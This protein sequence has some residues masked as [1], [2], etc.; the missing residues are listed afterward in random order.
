[1]PEDPGQATPASP[2]GQGASEPQTIDVGGQQMTPDALSKSYGELRQKLTD[3]GTELNTARTSLEG[4]AWADELQSRYN[5]D[6]TFRQSFDALFEEQTGTQNHALRPEN[7]ELHQT[8][9]EVAEMRNERAFD[10]IRQDG[11]ELS[12]D[13]ELAVLKEINAGPIKDAHAVYKNLFFDRALAKAR[14]QGVTDTAEQLSKNKDAY[15]KKPTAQGSPKPA[16]DVKSMSEEKRA[17]Y[18]LER[19]KEM[20]LYHQ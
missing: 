12:K 19:I 10:R 17:D 6:P 11:F 20:D 7:Q 8:R 5:T 9:M 13:D 16:P 18:L 1:M 14:T 4:K 2:E 3:Q 15:L